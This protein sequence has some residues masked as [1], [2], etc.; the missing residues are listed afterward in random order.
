[1]STRPL[2]I[3]GAGAHGR[4]VLELARLLDIKVAGFVDDVH[5]LKSS[6][7]D[8]EVLG[9]TALLDDKSFMA[10]FQGIVAIGNSIARRGFSNRIRAHGREPATLIHPAM[11]IPDSARIGSGCVLVSQIVVYPG[12]IIGQDVLI[13]PGVTFGVDNVIEDGVYICPGV[14]LGAYVTLREE[15]FVGMGAVVVPERTVGRRAVI[16]AG[17]VVFKDVPDGK[18][19]FGNPGRVTGDAVLDD[20]SPYPARARDSQTRVKNEGSETG[21]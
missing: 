6:I 10:P 14:H 7:D 11:K 4:A 2:L 5:P 19:V 9:R 20:F 17:A 13:D 21:S 15:C 1:M 8:C 3:V 12:V 18:L 16:G